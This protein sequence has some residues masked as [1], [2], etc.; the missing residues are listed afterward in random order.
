MLSAWSNLQR[1]RR[2]A[3]QLYELPHAQQMALHANINR[4]SKK[5]PKP[6]S[7]HD[8]T[9]FAEREEGGQFTPAVAAVALM[10]RH[11]DR[12]PPLL[13]SIWDQVLSSAREGVSPPS[14]KA[15]K[16]DDGSV[17]M[18]APSFE[19][20]NVRAG[21]AM[22]QGHQGGEVVVRDIE[23]Q[24][25]VYRVIVPVRGGFG[26]IEANTLFVSAET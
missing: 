9:L 8:F 15:L 19:G 25:A 4:D 2:E 6:F 3:A 23:R 16:S 26:W 10:L 20:G 22:V 7:L 5:C 14:V 12:C 13:I 18:L 17:W 1:I 21:L 11:E 24:L